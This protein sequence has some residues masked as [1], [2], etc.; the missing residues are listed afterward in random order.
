MPQIYAIPHNNGVPLIESRPKTLF[1]YP[2]APTLLGKAELAHKALS[3]FRASKHFSLFESEADA[4]EAYRTDDSCTYYKK[5]TKDSFGTFYSTPIFCVN[6][7]DDFDRAFSTVGEKPQAHERPFTSL[8]CYAISARICY[9]GKA[10]LDDRGEVYQMA[11]A[12]PVRLKSALTRGQIIRD[13]LK[14]AAAG[15]GMQF[16]S[17]ESYERGI[18]PEMPATLSFCL[19]VVLL[20]AIGKTIQSRQTESEYSD[21]VLSRISDA[22]TE[23]AANPPR[24]TM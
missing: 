12:S 18:T 19:G 5:G 6:V 17:G 24:K 11:S 16:F 15:F 7:P 9:V 10:W 20:A 14:L 21:A 22:T 3:C 4:I 8:H 23:K 1:D 13:V 2:M